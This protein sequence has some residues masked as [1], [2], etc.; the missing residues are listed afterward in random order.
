VLFRSRAP[1]HLGIGQEAVAVG[2]SHC[3]NSADRVFGGHRSHSHY[4]AL[5]GSV[6]RLLAEVLGKQDGAS[7]GMGGSMHLLGRDVGFY[8][9]VPIV[10]ATIPMAVGAA[11]AAQMDGKGAVGVAYFGD[12]ATEE[13]VF[14]ESMNLASNFKY[15]VLFVCEN[16][17]FSSHMHISLR[18][19]AD[20]IARYAE[21]HRVAAASV[22]G[23]DVVAIARA[24]QDLLKGVRAGKGPA[25]LEAITYRHRGHVGPSDDIDVGVAR[26]LEDLTSWKRRDPIDRLEKALSES[27][28]V[29]RGDFDALTRRLLDE[30]HSAS[31][32]AQAADYPPES[33]LL[34]RVYAKVPE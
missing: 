26:C 18:Q 25:F 16:N 12:G 7:R 27:G 29:A 30:V 20:R 11:I 32:R 8:G 21:A 33:A 9:S 28:I 10:G 2:V 1:C 24:T 4:L 14:H 19:P 22:D 3:L 13:G 15:P 17:L 23:N 6:Y 34:D 31:A 5:G